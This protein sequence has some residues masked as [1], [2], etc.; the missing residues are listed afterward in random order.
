[1]HSQN[2]VHQDLKPQNILFSEDYKT[3]KLA[4]LGVSSLLDRTKPT[5]SANCGTIR[6]M[7]PEQLDGI[8]TNKVDI[9][10]L[11]CVILETITGGQAPYF[12]L[13]NE[14]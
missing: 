1:M 3:V 11:G 6:Y 9:W 7:S 4:D 14:F 10:A 13:P 5:L 8:L 12:D 2:I